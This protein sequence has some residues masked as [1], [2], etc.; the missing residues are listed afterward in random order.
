MRT[1]WALTRACAATALLGAL[2]PLAAHAADAPAAPAL[3][4]A[5]LIDGRGHG[6]GVGMAQDGA[7]AM[8]KAGANVQK[9]LAQ[10]YPG[11]GLGKASGNVRVPVFSGN[12]VQLDFPDGGDI[13]GDSGA[14]HVA[15]GGSVVLY[16]DGDT[17]KVRTRSD[18]APPPSSTTT[19]AAPPPT[20]T[21]TTVGTTTTSSP[22]TTLLPDKGNGVRRSNDPSPSPS[23]SP[24]ITAPPPTTTTTTQPAASPTFTGSVTA[25]PMNG[26]RVGVP[27][28]GRR[29]R[30][31][32]DIAPVSGGLR[33][34]N[35]LNVETYLRGMGEVRNPN[36][37]AASLQAQ[38]IAARTYALRAM[39]FGG[40]LCDSQKCQ[41]YIG[42]DAEYAAMDKAVAATSGQVL[43]YGKS[44]ASAVYSANAGGRSASTEEGFGMPGASYPYLRASPYPTDNMD[45]WK[46]TIALKDIARLLNYPGELAGVAVVARGPSERATQVSLTGSAGEK[47]VTGLQ[48]D[49][50]LGLR[51][52]LFDVKPVMAARVAS[53]TGGSVLQ[54]PPEEAPAL[55][56]TTVVTDP[57]P[58][59]A[60]AIPVRA[61]AAP[62][63]PHDNVGFL[64]LVAAA[65][66]GAAVVSAFRWR[67]R[68]RSGLHWLS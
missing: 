42:S 57:L 51:S 32:I 1:C 36:W 15:P 64:S 61:S 16:R 9:I 2:S 30:G 60:A 6:H 4:P 25:T 43:T 52:T 45:P 38:A 44:L 37:P 28:R 41:V 66:W 14:L 11:T 21:T 17:T 24:T 29:Y 50:T 20:T 39:A 22:P 47:M 49:R 59:T 58:P 65:L 23:P 8:G 35:Q 67:R 48:F 3:I 12:N 55:A 68:V 19:T 34:V 40:E 33:F 13:R 27:D 7:L 31:L 18:T 10:F 26:G 54:A 46:V 5:L 63:A 53:I 56:D 62:V